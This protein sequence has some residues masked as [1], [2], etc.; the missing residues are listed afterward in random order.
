MKYLP[1][2]EKEQALMLEKIGAASIDEL[3]SSIPDSIRFRD[4][5][6]IG[7]HMDE[8]ALE[9]HM[10]DL[11]SRNGTNLPSFKGG[12]AYDHFYPAVVDALSTRSEFYTAYTPYQPEASQGHLQVF[13]EFQTMICNLT[14]MDVSNASMYDGAS[15]VAEAALMG[16]RVKRKNQKVAAAS[17]MHPEYLD[18]LRTYLKWADIPL[19]LVKTGE[20]GRVDADDL[21]EKIEGCA[22]FMF[23]NPNFFGVIEDGEKLCGFAHEHD[24][25]AGVSADP[26]SLGI[27]RKPG[28]YG[29][30]I[31]TGEG[32]SLGSPPYFG[33]HGF[34]FYTAKNDFIR[35]VPGRIVGQTNDQNGSSC[36]VLTLQAREQH[37]RR[38]RATSN[39]CSNQAWCVTRAVIHL[40]ALGPDGL[41]NAA[42]VSGERAH[43]LAEG[44]AA[45]DGFSLKYSAPF[46]KEFVLACP[47]PAAEVNDALEKNGILGGIDLGIYFPDRKN[48][49]LVCVTEKRTTEEIDTFIKTLTSL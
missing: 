8:I 12:G 33:G 13:F 9:A 22:V 15:A 46:F 10:A 38:E 32:Q 5:L 37:I 21:E 4:R 28:E 11:S 17:N 31:V 30:D 7:E 35:K 41:R 1:Q 2:T 43:A 44:A 42:C 27:L 40:A 16:C 48:E 26:V 18:V 20:D 47:K 45:A 24:A 34:G 19:V 6:G 49:M 29:A 3:F 39:I 23:A 14:G 36:Y 25:F